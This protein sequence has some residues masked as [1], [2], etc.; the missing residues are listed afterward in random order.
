[1]EDEPKDEPKLK[2]VCHPDDIDIAE[3]IQRRL[4]QPS[5]PLSNR[6]VERGRLYVIN[7][8]YLFVDPRFMPEALAERLGERWWLSGH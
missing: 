5:E 2:I 7:P 6:F 4:P 1:M 8:E 3:L